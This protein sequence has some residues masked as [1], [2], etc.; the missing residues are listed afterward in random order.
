MSSVEIL[1]ALTIV[2]RNEN[3]RVTVAETAQ[4][5]A[6]CAAGALIGGLLMGTRGLALGGAIVGLASCEL[7]ESL[8]DFKS[9]A[10][11]I[12]EDLSESERNELEEHVINAVNNITPVD[13][14]ELG[15]LIMTNPNIQ[16]LAMNAVKSFATNHL[17][18]TIID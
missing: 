14:L 18:H 17:G 4:G 11:V 10:D 2:A 9:L 1:F 12:S 8:L 15:F 3:I 6:I 5:V 16:S 7:A 13:V